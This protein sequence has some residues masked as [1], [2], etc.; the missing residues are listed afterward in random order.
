MFDVNL[1]YSSQEM[2]AREMAQKEITFL[3][4]EILARAMGTAMDHFKSEV[5]TND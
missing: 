1:K 5:V 2:T 3:S 4:S